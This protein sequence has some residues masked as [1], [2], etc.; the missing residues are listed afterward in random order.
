MMHRRIDVR[1]FARL[2]VP[3]L[4]VTTALSAPLIQQDPPAGAAQPGAGQAPRPR[5]SPPRPQQRQG[6]EYFAGTWRFSWVG[7]ESPITAGPRTGTVS[8]A[9]LGDSN[10]L[11]VRTE[12]ASDA[13]GAYKESGLLGWDAEK[14]V[15]VLS[16]RL[17]ADV[18]MLSIGDWSSPIAIRFE[19]S[20]L[21]VE[22][23]MLRLRRTYSILSAASF[24]VT[25]ELSTDGGPFVRLGTG[26]FRK[27]N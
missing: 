14:K 18:E 27:V 1:T 24:S 5:E 26:A 20:P 23:K 25:E 3:I 12:G 17:G 7:R 19:S 9:R 2:C 6:I 10:F 13:A 8:F 22:G 21:H 16:E 15:V 4:T 11:D